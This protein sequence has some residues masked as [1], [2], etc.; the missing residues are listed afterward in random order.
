MS[1]DYSSGRNGEF[2]FDIL[3]IRETYQEY[4]S[5]IEHVEEETVGDCASVAKNRPH[6]L[7]AAG[8][9]IDTEMV[10]SSTF[11]IFGRSFWLAR[12]LEDVL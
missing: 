6:P 4:A 8:W 5:S 11:R 9:S 2:T 3:K 1:L 12:S 7:D 10:L